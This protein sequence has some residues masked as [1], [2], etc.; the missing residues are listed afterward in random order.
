MAYSDTSSL[1]HNLSDDESSQD[2]DT[3]EEGFREKLRECL[4]SIQHE[5]TFSA[6]HHFTSY[7]NPGLHLSNHGSVGLPLSRRDAEAITSVC[8]QSPFGKGEQTIVDTSVR[9]TWELDCTEFRCENPAWTGFVDG[10]VKQAVEDLGVQVATRAERYKLLLYEK[11]AFFKAHKDSEKCPGMF[12][13]LVICLPSEHS[14]GEVHL[15][16]GSQSRTLETAQT[17]SFNL[18]TLAWYADVQHEVAP[19]TAGYRLVLTYNLVQDGIGPKQTAAVL[20]QKHARFERA[21]RLWNDDFCY[22]NL[23]IYPL[24]HQYTESSLCLKN[25][26][27]QDAAKG[28]CMQQMCSSN[29][30]YWF[31]GGLTRETESAFGEEE[32]QKLFLDNIVTPN[33][34]SIELLL[35]VDTDDILAEDLYHAGRDADSE[36]EGEYTGN[37]GTIDTYKYHDTVLIL[38]PKAKIFTYIPTYQR[39]LNSL[40]A[41]F[42]LIGTDEAA[43]DIG[44]KLRLLTMILSQTI[45]GMTA[46]SRHSHSY[47]SYANRKTEAEAATVAFHAFFSDVSAYCLS[48]GH[49][50]IVHSALR[51]AMKNPDWTSSSALVRLI[52]RHAAIDALNDNP[53]SWNDWF[54]NSIVKP[55]FKQINDQ[56]IA[57]E[58]LRNEL[59]AP[60][61]ST[62]S[63]W[64]GIRQVEML[65]RVEDLTTEDIPALVYLITTVSLETWN[66]V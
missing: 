44:T 49:K 38:V 45:S 23:F 36:D 47:I 9:K 14:G 18:S 1:E 37:E 57:L 6:F 42:E 53:S 63:D 31:L 7:V 17:S 33:G 3:T 40:R 52:A 25:L 35:D 20:D 21:L 48:I 2:D 56:C 11:G 19:V 41:F 60:T 28:R 26:K 55:T 15:V 12:G 64:L 39:G 51:N 24:E 30:V 22:Q 4:D 59:S 66:E 54:C 65:R 29:G 10:L 13:T 58:P 34:T 43:A 16:H 32:E 5:G 62:F 61:V 27:G 50:S 46:Q 8:K